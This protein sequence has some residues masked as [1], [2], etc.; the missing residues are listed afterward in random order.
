[1]IQFA[2]ESLIRETLLCIQIKDI[3]G[4]CFKIFN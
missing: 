3:S 2:Q 4:I 1:M